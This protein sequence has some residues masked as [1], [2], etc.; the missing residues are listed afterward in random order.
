M[1]NN[2]ELMASFYV[3]VFQKGNTDY[4]D[5]VCVPNV[6]WHDPPPGTPA[7]N[8]SLKEFTRMFHSAFTEQEWEVDCLTEEGDTLTWCGTFKAVHTGDFLNVPATNKEVSVR[9]ID[10]IKVNS[11]GKCT[12]HWG[13][14]D[15]ASMLMQL[16]VLPDP[17]A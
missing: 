9:N 6:V 3:E 1:S 11:D 8:E 10:V 17:T 16:G 14:L 12:E 13:V 5:E 7:T 4:I 15:F 2:K